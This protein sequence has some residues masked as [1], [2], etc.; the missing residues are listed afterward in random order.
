MGILVRSMGIRS[1]ALSM[2]RGLLVVL[3]LVV[4]LAETTEAVETLVDVAE[5]MRVEAG[6]GG[7]YASIPG[8][9]VPGAA[10]KIGGEEEEPSLSGCQEFCSEREDCFAVSYSEATGEC[11]WSSH[12]LDYDS[13]FTLYALSPDGDFVGLRGMKQLDDPLAVPKKL[14]EEECQ[15]GCVD[16]CKGFSYSPSARHC[17]MSKQG[18]NFDNTFTYYEKNSPR[19]LERVAK[20][21]SVKASKAAMVH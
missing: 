12:T 18:V 8:L 7:V 13:D 2:L 9:K 20:A 14:S 21:L 1:K 3:P 17:F 4:F 10:A 6:V 19:D 5:T 15:Q 16:T 11:F